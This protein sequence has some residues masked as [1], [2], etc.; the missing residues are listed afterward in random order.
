MAACLRVA[1]RIRFPRSS[2]V[3]AHGECRTPGAEHVR[4]RT[5]ALR[6][7]RDVASA[8]GACR[9]SDAIVAAAALCALLP[10]VIPLGELDGNV[11]F[12]AI[13]LVPVGRAADSSGGRSRCSCSPSL[14]VR[15]SLWALAFRS[16]R[17]RS[18]R[19]SFS[20][21][22]VVGMAAHSSMRVHSEWTRSAAWGTADPDWIDAAVVTRA[23]RCRVLWYEPPGK[24]FVDLEA[25][26]RILFVGEF[27]NR[28]VGNVYELG[29]PL[30]YGASG[31]SGAPRHGPRGARGRASRGSRRLCA[32]AVP[33]AGRRAKSSAETRSPGRGWFGVSEP[34]RVSVEDPGLVRGTR[35]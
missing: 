26:H 1:R 11:R 4:A 14:S 2:G 30:P 28:S 21:L 33:R 20:S 12:Q 27:F 19:R 24:P 3:L 18:S 32:R 23:T 9:W 34:V 31:D 6:R 5:D 10:A 25:R 29:S 16:R 13:S 8:A 15:S 22:L 7:P 35:Q 17:W